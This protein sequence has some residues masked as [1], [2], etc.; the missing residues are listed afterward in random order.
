MAVL[1]LSPLIAIVAVAYPLL[2]DDAATAPAAAA[3]RAEGRG[4]VPAA[5]APGAARSADRAAQPCCCSTDRIE[6]ALARSESDP[7]AMVMV[8]FLDLDLF[9]VVNDSLGHHAGDELADGRLTASARRLSARATRWPGSEA[10]SSSSM[11]E[12]D[13]AAGRGDRARLNRIAD[14]RCATRSPPSDRQVTVSASVGVAVAGDDS[15]AADPAAGRGHRHVPREGSAA[16]TKSSSS[17]R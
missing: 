4:D 14:A 7:A 15:D 13:G 6:Q 9:K 5:G 8:M 3:R 10:T 1:A 12:D 11:C 16:A 17:T 2:V